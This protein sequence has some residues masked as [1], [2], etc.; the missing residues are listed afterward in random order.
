M[1][2]PSLL[3]LLLLL[4]LGCFAQMDTV[5]TSVDAAAGTYTIGSKA[6]NWQ[7]SGSVGQPLDHVSRAVSRDEAGDYESIRFAWAKG[8]YEAAIRRYINVPVVVFTLTLPGGDNDSLISFPDFKKLPG[9]L[10]HFSYHN[11]NFARPEFILNNTS[12]PW[13]LFDDHNRACIISPASHFMVAKM[14][15]DGIQRV[16]SSINEEVRKYPKGF[17]YSTIMVLGTGIHKCWDQW[18]SALR[19]LYHRKFPDMENDPLLKYY[20][21]WTDNGADYYYNYDTTI[22]YAN[23]LLKLNR[24]YKENKLPLGYMQLDSWWYEKSVT[25]PDGKPDADH[26]NKNLP[27][28]AWNRYG[29]LMAYQPDT[30]LFPQGLSSFRQ[31]LGLPLA[32]HNRWIDPQSPYHQKY[33][34]SGFAAIDPAFWKEIMTDLKTWGVVCYEQDWLNYIYAK[35]PAMAS[36]LSVGDLFADGMA[37]EADKLGIHLQ[38]CMAMPRFFLQ[39][40]KYNNLTTIRTSEDR[41][42]PEKWM[43][44]LFTSQL[45][46]ATGALPWCDVFKSHETGNMILSVLSSGPVGTGD[47]I[48]K[49]DKHNIFLACRTDGQ[50]VRPDVPLL[51][52]DESYISLAEHKHAPILAYTYTRHEAVTTGYLFAFNRKRDGEKYFHVQPEKLGLRGETIVFDPTSESVTGMQAGAY[53]TDTLPASGYAYYIIAPVNASGIA[54]FGDKDKI[55][56]TGKKRIASITYDGN[57]LKIK[58]LFAPEEN[59]ITLLGYCKNNIRTSDGD[60]QVD[61]T[62]GVFHLVVRKPSG[63]KDVNI[64]LKKM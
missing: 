34:I 29:G 61:K 33:K 58:V 64:E 23:T 50:L 59:E 47:L 60:L 40:L 31:Q 48:G 9:D 43:P 62:T 5:Y 32:V 6:L 22:G 44:F 12:T 21:Y 8:K 57:T 18:G 4:T 17:T 28:G 26:K 13:L 2:K 24:Y 63:K 11:D 20:G 41:F 42:N 7:F 30:F 39:G 10:L 49:E 51:P 46:Y 1:K 14:K 52:L 36:D 27:F 16:A 25:D 55:A 38:Y 15:G 19:A 53:F 37:K 35:T 56:S 45:A 3:F 54:F